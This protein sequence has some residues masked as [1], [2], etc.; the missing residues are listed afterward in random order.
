MEADMSK[1]EEATWNDSDDGNVETNM[2][3]D[4]A[5]CQRQEIGDRGSEVR[6][7]WS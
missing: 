7:T 3:W 1:T 5:Q 6:M 2:D 4:G